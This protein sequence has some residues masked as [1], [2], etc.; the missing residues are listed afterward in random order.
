M[1]AAVVKVIHGGGGGAG[2]FEQLQDFLLT[3]QNYH[4]NSWRW[5][6]KVLVN[7]EVQMAVILFSQLHISGGGGGG[8][9]DYIQLVVQE[10]WWWW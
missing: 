7:V 9:A 8:Q 6:Y 5:W 2:G 3:S 10:V 1:V 4:Y